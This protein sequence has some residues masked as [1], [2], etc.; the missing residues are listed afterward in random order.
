MKVVIIM[1]HEL[2]FPPMQGGGV[3]YLVDGLSQGIAK[4]GASVKVIAPTF[5]GQPDR[6]T[7]NGVEMVRIQGHDRNPVKWKNYLVGLPYTMRAK[8]EIGDA[9]LVMCHFLQ[10]PFLAKKSRR[11]VLT[12]SVH[13]DPKFF[14]KYFNGVDRVYTATQAIKDAVAEVNPLLR[15]RCKIIY[16]GVDFSA[17]PAPVPLPP[18][19]RLRFLFIGRFTTCKGLIGLLDGF[20]AAAKIRPDIELLTVGPQ[21]A[22][23][24]AEPELL[25]RLSKV[26]AASGVQDRI[27]FRGPVF[28]RPEIDAEFAACHVLLL[29]SEWGETLNMSVVEST[30]IGRPVLISDVDTNLPLLQNGLFGYFVKSGSADAW[31][32]AI[33]KMADERDKLADF[34]KAAYKFGKEQF[35]VPA[36]SQEYIDDFNQLISARKGAG[37]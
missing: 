15:D 4:L 27:E 16:N 25:E 6:E 8:K 34:G 36:L 37:R 11:Y 17:Y 20:I 33:L 21:D 3:N 22:V 32:D 29:P 7:K 5:P 26:A 13:R 12:H 14:L 23:G 35:S 31:R 30:R 24:G 28:K 10:T 19:N 2:P 1:G 18:T 9:D